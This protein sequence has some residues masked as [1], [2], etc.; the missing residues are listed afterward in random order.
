MTKI[1]N[2]MKT[3]D[4]HQAKL[5]E[6]KFGDN[7]K[8]EEVGVTTGKEVVTSN[9]GKLGTLVFVVRRPG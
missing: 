2:T 3:S 4:L 1:P 8:V 7:D 9:P 5:V 6:L